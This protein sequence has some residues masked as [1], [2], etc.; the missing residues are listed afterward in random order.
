MR[1]NEMRARNLIGDWEERAGNKID[2][3]SSL[4]YLNRRA[5]QEKQNRDFLNE[6]Q[7][8]LQE[9]EKREIRKGATIEWPA[10]SGNLVTL[11]GLSGN[12]FNIKGRSE[13]VRLME[14]AGELGILDEEH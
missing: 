3:V 13:K 5:L 9:L 11:G 6:R 8:I 14:L 4:D 7:R 12:H 1:R 10:G 2:A